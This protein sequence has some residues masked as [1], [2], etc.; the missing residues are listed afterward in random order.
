M[1][2][3]TNMPHWSCQTS[4]SKLECQPTWLALYV[5]TVVETIYLPTALSLAMRLRLSEIEQPAPLAMVDEVGVVEAVLIVVLVVAMAEAIH[6]V[7]SIESLAPQ[8]LTR[9]FA[10]LKAKSIVPARNVVGI[11][12]TMPTRLVDTLLMWQTLTFALQP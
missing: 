11:G 7:I 2:Q 6:V 5:T 8:S 9:S 12:V 1:R 4:G 3:M 10:K